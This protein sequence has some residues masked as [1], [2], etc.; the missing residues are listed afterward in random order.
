MRDR[1]MYHRHQ[2]RHAWWSWWYRHHSD[3]E[4]NWI[5]N[6]HRQT[7]LWRALLPNPLRYVA[8]MAAA[9]WALQDCS[10]WEQYN[11]AFAHSW[12]DFYPRQELPCQ[13]QWMSSAASFSTDWRGASTTKSMN[14][15]LS[16]NH[17]HQNDLPAF[18]LFNVAPET[19]NT[20][21][22]AIIMPSNSSHWL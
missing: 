22:F 7:H 10:S 3:T 18:I 13:S 17:S 8:S 6:L 21:T 5:P 4:T 12:T 9:S 19:I 15:R 2:Q 16:E 11:F 20:L 1:T 14:R